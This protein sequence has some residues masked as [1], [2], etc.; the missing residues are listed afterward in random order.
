MTN[1]ELINALTQKPGVLAFG[2]NGPYVAG[3]YVLKYPELA[4]LVRER[5]AELK[6]WIKGE[7]V[8]V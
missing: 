6:V 3:L 7:M 4:A 8:S 1:E 5:R 2:H